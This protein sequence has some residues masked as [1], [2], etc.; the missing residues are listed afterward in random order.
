MNK[1]QV[2]GRAEAAK[3]KVEEV[4]GKLVGNKDLEQKG[5]IDQATGKAQAFAGDVK[6]DIKNAT[7]AS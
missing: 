4:A 5:K 6:E 7:K 1:Y 3:G 2:Q